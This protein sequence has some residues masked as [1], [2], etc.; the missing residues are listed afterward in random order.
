[1]ATLTITFTAPSPAPAAGYNVGYRKQGSGGAYEVLF[2]RPSASPASIPV[3]RGYDYEGYI[4]SDCD[5]GAPSSQVSW[6]ASGSL[7]LIEVPGMSV[8]P[9]MD[10]YTDACGYNVSAGELSLIYTRTGALEYG[11][12]VYT[13]SHGRNNLAGWMGGSA[14]YKTN[15]ESVLQIDEL[16]HYAGV[17]ACGMSSGNCTCSDG[18]STYIVSPGELCND[19]ST[20]SC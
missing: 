18:D 10:N 2:P 12:P 4:E 6:T 13:D 7:N 14:W 11:E 8:G 9:G 20:P 1:M 16:H 5:S 3:D 17:I 15:E 19:G